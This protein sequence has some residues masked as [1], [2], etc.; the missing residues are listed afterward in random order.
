MLA[1]AAAGCTKEQGGYESLTA[2]QTG[3]AVTRSFTCSLE[4][5]YRT[6]TVIG[7]E[8]GLRSVKWTEGD[9]V[10]IISGDGS[11]VVAGISTAGNI[12]EV[13]LMQSGTY[14]A[15]YPADTETS[16]GID[17]L[18]FTIPSSQ[19][20][21]FEDANY[22]VAA[23]DDNERN[24]HFLNMVSMLQLDITG[25]Y[26][27]VIIRSNDGSALIGKQTIQIDPDGTIT[28][29]AS[30]T[31]AQIE[32]SVNGTG[33]YYVAMLADAYLP[34]GLGFRFFKDNEPVSGVLSV[35]ALDAERSSIRTLAPTANITS[36]WYIAPDGTGNGLRAETPGGVKLFTSLLSVNIAEGV[37]NEG[38]TNAWRINGAT[39]HLAEGSY[40]LKD[41][42]IDF[43]ETAEFIVKGPDNGSATLTTADGTIVTIT[44]NCKASFSKVRF[45]GGN[46]EANGGAIYITTGEVHFQQ[47]IFDGNSAAEVG[48]HISMNTSD[49]K[50]F[51]N[52][53][54][55]KNGTANTKNS[56][57]WP[58][59]AIHS[60][61]TEATLCINNSI[62]YNNASAN[63]T[64]NDGL[65]CIRTNG[66]K[67]LIL[68]SS[69]AH[70]G[71]R[72]LNATNGGNAL[73]INNMSKNLGTRPIDMANGGTRKYNLTVS[74]ATV[75]DTNLGDNAN[76]SINWT[77]DT[78]TFTWSLTN[79]T[80]SKWATETVISD[81]VST[82]FA[83][84]DSWLK[85]VETNPYGIDFY[86]NSRNTQKFNPGAWDEGLN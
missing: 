62:F 1:L 49:P 12:E 25:D 77:E 60:A 78:N 6:K 22:M 57:G 35:A 51:V 72:A 29:A 54:V 15:A 19:N 59:A 44:A 40:T 28:I 30:E 2:E 39:I 17:G 67:T 66:V 43:K 71:I 14:Y 27:K 83:A 13:T 48:A 16:F 42:K 79:V 85:S 4:G 69:F 50:V 64:I 26:D 84:F 56:T 36:D 7:N 32:L 34:A 70:K 73:V 5:E 23:T 58:G 76:L 86:G 74:N 45:S 65:P 21:K 53:C 3:T 82:N 41:F 81:L 10:K 38:Y 31:S 61:N 20:G 52:R 80:I 55:F 24:F 46:A 68:N 18:A 11:E 8:E 33:T 63:I 37:T 47:C 9:M 75:D